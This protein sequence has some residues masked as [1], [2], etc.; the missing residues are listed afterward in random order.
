M[1][2]EV[3]SELMKERSQGTLHTVG[4]LLPAAMTQPVI[5]NENDAT[6][7]ADQNFFKETVADLESDID[8][9]AM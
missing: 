5:V 4:Y 9:V 6:G 8:M 2:T 1:H 7:Q 3:S